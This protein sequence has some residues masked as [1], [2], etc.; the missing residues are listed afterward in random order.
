MF[1][2]I[3]FVRS[4]NIW[5]HRLPRAIPVYNIDGT[6]NKVGHITEVV[7]LMSNTKTTPNGQH[8]MLRESANYNFPRPHM[9][10]GT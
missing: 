6:P 4:K 7:D 9:A 1:I 3:E 10:H 2:D 5:T 8:S